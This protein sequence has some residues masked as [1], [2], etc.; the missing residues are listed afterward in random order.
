MCL[1]IDKHKIK[2]TS[3]LNYLG[4]GLDPTLSWKGHIDKICKKIRQKSNQLHHIARNTCGLSP[5]HCRLIYKEAIEPA[6][7]YAAQIWGGKANLVHVK[8][9]LLSVQRDFAIR[10]CRA[11]RTTPTDALLVM[12]NLVPIH[13]KI[14]YINWIWNI[15]N[16]D[17]NISESDSAQIITQNDFYHNCKDM[18]QMI[19]TY[20]LD[21]Q[22]SKMK[23]HH[24]PANSDTMSINLLYKTITNHARW[25]V[26]T[27]GA[28]NDKGTGVAFTIRDTVTNTTSKEEYHKLGK[29]CSNNQAEL[30]SMQQALIAITKHPRKYQDNIDFFTDSRYVLNVINGTNKQTAAGIKVCR[31]ANNLHKKRNIS[32]NWIPG[33]SRISGNERA[34]AL[35][36]EVATLNVTPSFN[37]VPITLVKSLI[38]DKIMNEWQK[39]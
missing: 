36:K 7:L 9:K 31:L 25:H 22:S 5:K 17:L 6:L 18:I 26:F 38:Y 1:Y 33:H 21:S 14:K 34:D 23:Y 4:V 37:K 19:Q 32:F 29:H 24:H 15:Q 30:W 10:I 12:A 28:K 27:D 13:L 39:E 35:A 11:Y 8:R 2:I 3:E 16:E 20:G